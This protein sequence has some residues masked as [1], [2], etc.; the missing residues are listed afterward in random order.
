MTERPSWTLSRAAEECGVSRDTLKRRRAAGEFPNAYM[1]T[2]GKWLI[3][4]NDLLAAGFK[5]GGNTAVHENDAP[6]QAPVQVPDS[7]ASELVQQVQLLQVQLEAER[8][9]R[10]AAERNADDLRLALRMI[11]AAPSR[12]GID[13]PKAQNLSPV[14]NP[15]PA[16]KVTPTS[17]RRHWW[18]L[19]P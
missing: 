8:N 19:L 9:M 18:S 3:P 17:R 12:S 16:T 13:V 14:G 15:T 2:R 7:R 4:V 10:Q 6:V 1:D 5:P 11:E